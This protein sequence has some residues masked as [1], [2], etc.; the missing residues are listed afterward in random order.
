MGKIIVTAWITL[1]GYVAGP[2]DEMDWLLLD[3]DL[4]RYEQALVDKASALLLGRITHTDFANAWPATAADPDGDPATRDY[5]RRVC[6]LAKVVVSRSGDITP[7]EGTTRLRSLERASIDDLKARQDGHIVVYGSLSVVGALTALGAVDEYHLLV[8]PVLLGAGKPLH[9]ER[10]PLRTLSVDTF[11][12]GVT[13]NK[14]APA[15]AAV[16]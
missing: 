10:L 6:E 5:A 15:A 13:L 1:D 11:S 16:S 8:H 3:S 4:M 9:G 14:Y 7:W 2:D 12:S